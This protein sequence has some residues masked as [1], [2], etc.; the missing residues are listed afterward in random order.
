VL[1][2]YRPFDYPFGEAGSPGTRHPGCP[3]RAE[4]LSKGAAGA[5]RSEL[6]LDSAVGTWHLG[7]PS[8]QQSSI[9]QTRE[10]PIV[11]LFAHSG[12]A[13]SSYLQDA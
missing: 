13:S 12:D 5:E 9:T 10:D 3:P 11:S 8:A 2:H 4:T 1:P 7:R 6:A